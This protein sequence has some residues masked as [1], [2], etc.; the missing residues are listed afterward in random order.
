MSEFIALA[1]APSPFLS[2]PVEVSAF[3]PNLPIV[4]KSFPPFCVL[5]FFFS[6]Q[7]VLLSHFEVNFAS[8]L[9]CIS[10]KMIVRVVA[11][12]AVVLRAFSI[13]FFV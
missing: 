8:S 10:L 12:L 9:F 6:V 7:F 4:P 13:Q 2:K 5:H 1:P 3:V 11:L